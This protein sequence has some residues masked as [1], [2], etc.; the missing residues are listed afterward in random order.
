MKKIMVLERKEIFRCSIIPIS[1]SLLVTT[2]VCD[3]VR[4][5]VREE[6]WF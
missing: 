1:N 2:R 5:G 4:V 3:S 6:L